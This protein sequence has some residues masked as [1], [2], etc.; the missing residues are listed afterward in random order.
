MLLL[1]HRDRDPARR[2]RARR[3]ARHARAGRARRLRPTRARPGTRRRSRPRSS[4]AASRSASTLD[5]VSAVAV[6]I[7]PGMFT[8]LRV[9]VTTAKVLAQALRVP[10]IPIPS[11]DLL[12]YPLRHAR[13]L[14]VRDDRRAPPR[15][16]LGDLPARCPAACSACRSTSSARP[17][18]SSPS[19]R[20]AARTRWCAATARCGSPTR[21]RRSERASSSRDPR[22]R[23]RASARLSSSRSARLRA[24]RVL[25]AREVLPMYLR[26]SD[27]ELAWDR[28]GRCDGGRRAR[29]SSARGAHRRRCAAGTCAASCGSRR[30]VYPRPWSHSLFVSELA[31]R[32]S[33]VVRGRQGRPRGR[34]LRGA[35][36]V[37]RPTG[38]SRRSPS[39]PAWHRQR[40][41]HAAAARARARGDRAR[42][43]R[44]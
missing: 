7:G 34:R 5:Q 11:L 42:R 18:I 4:G 26:Q 30:Q 39:I 24:R 13:R 14:V 17:T 19:S 33:R 20:R 29:S 40:D 1:G 43:A 32:S 3:R 12:A 10:V 16:L 15:A 27:A 2:R 6:G 22:T 23:R 41:R 36:D 35:D 9:G 38:T 31:L 28:K 8:G 21:S 37:A 44:R 25:R